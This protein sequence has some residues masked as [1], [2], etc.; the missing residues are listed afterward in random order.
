MERLL[1]TLDDLDDLLGAV[2]LIAERLRNLV[3]FSGF[4]LLLVVVGY[5]GIALALRE[6][7][8]A[9]AMAILLFVLL[10]YRS[11]TRPIHAVPSRS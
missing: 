2:G 8:L 9:M 5:A 4:A 10:L 7:P 6:P 11:V 3:W 1:Q